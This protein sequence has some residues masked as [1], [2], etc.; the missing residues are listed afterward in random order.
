MHELWIPLR[1]DRA[2]AM[3][4][5]ELE[6]ID[7]SNKFSFRAACY[8]SCTCSKVRDLYLQLIVHPVLKKR[9]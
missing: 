8:S 2:I 5:R 6:I 7:R 4:G 9:L 1:I 3:S